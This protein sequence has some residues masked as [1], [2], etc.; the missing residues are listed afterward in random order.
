[1]LNK[2]REGR[3]SNA[4]SITELSKAT[5]HKSKDQ[6]FFFWYLRKGVISKELTKEIDPVD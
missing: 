3:K 6:E 4:M 1:M 2:R 5:E